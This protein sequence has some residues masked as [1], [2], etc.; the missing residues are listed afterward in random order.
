MLAHVTDVKILFHLNVP[1][2]HNNNKSNQL[3]IYFRYDLEDGKL[4]LLCDLIMR[5]FRAVDMSGGI[6]NFMPF[7]RHVA[8]G[9]SGY[10]E[11]RSIHKALHDFLGV[12]PFKC[13]NNMV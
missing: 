11:L 10:N 2:S 13:V 9:L 8:P 7:M 12:S 6:L 3:F 4:K 1:L 5:L